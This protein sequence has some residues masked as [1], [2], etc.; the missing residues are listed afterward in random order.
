MCVS[1]VCPKSVCLLA[2]V[3]S[4]NLVDLLC[5]SANC[6]LSN[7]QKSVFLWCLVANCDCLLVLLVPAWCMYDSQIALQLCPHSEQ[8]QKQVQDFQSLGQK[9]GT[10]LILRTNSRLRTRNGSYRSTGGLQLSMWHEQPVCDLDIEKQVR[11]LQLTQP[12][13]ILPQ[14]WIVVD[15]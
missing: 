9:R 13:L 14:P 2:I 3:A 8:N 4:I 5:L 7:K 6:G 15:G 10:D 11:R 1:F 12:A